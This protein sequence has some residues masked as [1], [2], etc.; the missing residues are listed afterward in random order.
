MSD[1]CHINLSIESK[2]ITLDSK[3]SKLGEIKQDGETNISKFTTSA[4][5]NLSSPELHVVAENG[6]V[7][8]E[9]QSWAA[10]LGFNLPNS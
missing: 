1:S 5:P 7:S 6:T 2:N 4:E 9:M 8:V 3:L 10:S